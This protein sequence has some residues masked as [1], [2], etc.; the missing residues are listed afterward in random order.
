VPLAKAF[1]YLAAYYGLAADQRSHFYIGYRAVRN[2]RPISEFSATIVGPGGAATPLAVDARG[3]VTRP[4]SAEQMKAGGD[5]VIA[6]PDANL[7]LEL[8]ASIAPAAQ[9]ETGA[10]AA[11]LAQVNTDIAKFAG[12]LSLVAPKMTAAYFPDAGVGRAVLADGQASPLPVFASP[13]VGPVAYFEPASQS[14]ARMVVLSRAPSRI[15]LG[16][17]PKT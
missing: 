1:P 4:P 8:R 5:L 10:L 6:T 2:R 13:I 15:V 16:A 7:G 14:A 9:V 17:H 3:F 12:A 11:A